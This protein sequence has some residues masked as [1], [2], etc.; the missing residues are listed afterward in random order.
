MLKNRVTLSCLRPINELDL[1]FLSQLYAS[2]RAAELALTN[3]SNDQKTVFLN[4]QFQLQHNY[5]QQ[6][7]ATAKFHII[8]LNGGAI[9]RLYYGWQSDN[10]LHLIDVALSPEHQRN[11]IG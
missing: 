10:D 8:E 6:Q 3:W 1:P 7:F 2:T 11:A 4:S 9:G 5:Y